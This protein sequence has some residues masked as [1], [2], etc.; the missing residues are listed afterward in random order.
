MGAGI[1]ERGER[2]G[3]E[4]GG[5]R[6]ESEEGWWGG[7]ISEMGRWEKVMEVAPELV[8]AIKGGLWPYFLDFLACF[9]GVG[10]TTGEM[11]S[12]WIKESRSRSWSEK[13]LSRRF[14]GKSW[15]WRVRVS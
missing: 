14:S 15:E 3:G 5:G 9:G 7:E 10:E 13:P 2:G 1:G 6:A 4:I 11:E 8:R 12:E